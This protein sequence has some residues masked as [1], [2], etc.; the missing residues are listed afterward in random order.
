MKTP[1]IKI[2][3]KSQKGFC[4]AGHKVGDSWILEDTKTPGGICLDGFA[5]CITFLTALKLGAKL[6]FS[7]DPDVGKWC[8]RMRKILWFLRSGVCGTQ[9]EK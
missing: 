4:S 5:C 1:V 6:P 2:T 3:V 8:A 7:G 9:K